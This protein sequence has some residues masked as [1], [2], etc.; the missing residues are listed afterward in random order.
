[1]GILPEQTI[2]FSVPNPQAT[3]QFSLPLYQG[4]GYLGDFHT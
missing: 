2:D 1:M 3:A 4:A